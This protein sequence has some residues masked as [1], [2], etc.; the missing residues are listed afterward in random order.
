MLISG[1]VMISRRE[2]DPKEAALDKD[3]WRVLNAI[4]LVNRSL[5]LVPAI[6]LDIY[7][8]DPRSRLHPLSW[9]NKLTAVVG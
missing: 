3:A 4:W 5:P 7:S 6:L 1:P 9:K 2:Q 8:H